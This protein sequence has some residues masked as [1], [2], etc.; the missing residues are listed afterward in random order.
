MHSNGYGV[1]RIS[2]Y[3]SESVIPI[4]NDPLS[5]IVLNTLIDICL[6]EWMLIQCHMGAQPARS[7]RR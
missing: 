3:V 1:L 6:Y 7:E 4:P 5:T 2:R